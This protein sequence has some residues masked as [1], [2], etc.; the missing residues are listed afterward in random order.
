[1][2]QVQ[3]G[4]LIRYLLFK[5]DV[6]AQ[7]R[8]LLKDIAFELLFVFTPLDKLKALDYVFFFA[9]VLLKCRLIG[10]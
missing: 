1:M 8:N 7:V 10:V 2:L 9:Q 4:K 5:V 3:L 6:G